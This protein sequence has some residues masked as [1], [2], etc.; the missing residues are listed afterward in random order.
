MF[1]LI[2]VVFALLV[3]ATVLYAA[4][5]LVKTVSDPPG[6]QPEG[7]LMNAKKKIQNKNLW[8]RYINWLKGD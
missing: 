5:S 8:T 7:S 6:K 1:G 3:C 2:L 4:W